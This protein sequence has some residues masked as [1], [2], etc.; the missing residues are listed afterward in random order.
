MIR[1]L[2]SLFALALFGAILPISRSQV[3][4]VAKAPPGWEPAA[5]RDEIKP[6]F[7]FDPKGGPHGLGSLGIVA[8]PRD[9]LHGW[10]QKSFP[11]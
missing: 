9:G 3:S 1:L 10:W 4:D 6:R 5:P 2:K 8:E 11:Y 7:S